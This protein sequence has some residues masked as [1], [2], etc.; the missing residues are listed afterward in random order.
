MRSP[1]AQRRFTPPCVVAASRGASQVPTT[2]ASL[3][4]WPRPRSRAP[5]TRP[6]DRA[7][8][9]EVRPRPAAAR[10]R[11][12]YRRATSAANRRV[13]S[14]ARSS[15]A[16]ALPAEDADERVV[17]ARGDEREQRTVRDHCRSRVL[18]FAWK[19]F[20]PG[21]SRRSARPRPG[22]RSGMRPRRPWARSPARPLRPG[23]SV[24]PRE[25]AP[26]RSPPSGRRQRSGSAA[27]VPVRAVIAA[28]DVDHPL[29]SA[30]GTRRQLLP[31]VARA[32]RELPG[33]KHGALGDQTLRRPLSLNVHASRCPAAVSSPGN[34]RLATCSSVNPSPAGAG[35]SQ[36]RS[37]P[38]W[39]GRRSA[40]AA[41]CEGPG[42]AHR[43]SS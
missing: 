24:C 36:R 30:R 28:S 27:R 5:T 11:A 32:T 1:A 7:A 29:P 33:G 17:V 43:V 18:P 3:L 41:R 23:P 14:S 12:V 34:G 6:A 37:S 42:D 26:T 20:L 16:A 10:T 2:A 21:D 35:F 39:S 19:S 9:P 8:A 13:P 40:P 22:R 25:T 31:V 15:A 38:L 4:R